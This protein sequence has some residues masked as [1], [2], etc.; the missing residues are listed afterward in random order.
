MDLFLN[1]LKFAGI[2]VSGALGILGTVTVTRS[3]RTGRLNHWGKWALCLTVAG[4][5]TALVSQ[6][7][8]LF[9]EHHDILQ[10]QARIEE[11]MAVEQSTLYRVER[12]LTRFDTIS[13]SVR[14]E[15]VTNS[16]PLLSLRNYTAYWIQTNML[17]SWDSSETNLESYRGEAVTFDGS[18]SVDVFSYNDSLQLSLPSPAILEGNSADTPSTQDFKDFYFFIKNPCLAFAL[19]APNRDCSQIPDLYFTTTNLNKTP[20]LG[21]DF[22]S[23]KFFIEWTFDCPKSAWKQSKRMTSLPD[24]PNSKLYL[25]FLNSPSKITSTLKPL[26]VETA[27]D[28]TKLKSWNFSRVIL[29]PEAATGATIIPYTPGQSPPENPADNSPNDT[30][31][32]LSDAGKYRISSDNLF[33]TVIPGG[34]TILNFQ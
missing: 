4:L 27:F 23:G 6:I 28:L 5:V 20:T 16:A 11:Q 10:A 17:T 26:S 22:S 32:R 12:I 34:D 13:I 24:L 15:L 25:S 31:P 14:Y 18:N 30:Y 33:L 19:Y 8:Q 7:A 2:I 3:K 9:K 29:P 21:L 1:I